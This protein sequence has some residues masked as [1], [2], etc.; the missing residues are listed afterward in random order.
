MLHQGMKFP[1]TNQLTGSRLKKKINVANL[2]RYENGDL[3]QAYD[4]VATQYQ[5]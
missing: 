4:S 3:L 2:L 5:S 1:P